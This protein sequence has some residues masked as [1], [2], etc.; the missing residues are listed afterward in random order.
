MVLCLIFGFNEFLSCLLTINCILGRKRIHIH[1]IIYHSYLIP[2][3]LHSSITHFSSTN[4]YWTISS[5]LNWFTTDH[6]EALAAM[7]IALHALYISLHGAGTINLPFK[8]M[9]LLPHFLISRDLLRLG[10]QNSCWCI[11]THDKELLD[12]E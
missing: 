10:P 6:M 5:T 4:Y 7:S 2:N 8:T 11:V 12:H 3:P 1:N 9:F